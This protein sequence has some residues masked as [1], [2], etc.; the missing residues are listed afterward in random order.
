MFEVDEGMLGPEALAKFFAGDEFSGTFQQDGQDFDGLAVEVELVA[1]LEEFAGLGIELKRPEADFIDS[2]FPRALRP[3]CYLTLPVLQI[4]R[5]QLIYPAITQ[6]DD[7]IVGRE[8]KP[9]RHSE[10][11]TRSSQCL[12]CRLPS[13]VRPVRQSHAHDFT[14]RIGKTAGQIQVASPSVRERRVAV[15]VLLIHR[16]SS[17]GG[18]PDV[19]QRDLPEVSKTTPPGSSLSRDERQPK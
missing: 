15:L 12:A 19:E 17:S 6:D 13:P 9:A 7:A 1:K 2:T 5:I 3:R 11:G 14:V 16:G 4:Q 18:F 10:D 8:R